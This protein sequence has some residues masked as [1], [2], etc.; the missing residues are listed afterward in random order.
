MRSP[1]QVQLLA[2]SHK[3]T[4]LSTNQAPTHTSEQQVQ[5]QKPSTCAPLAFPSRLQAGPS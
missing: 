2:R 3:P 1:N 4:Q 5:S